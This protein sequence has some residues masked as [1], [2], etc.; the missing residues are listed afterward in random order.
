GLTTYRLDEIRLPAPT[1]FAVAGQQLTVTRVWRLTDLG[2]A[3]CLEGCTALSVLIYDRSVLRE[4]STIAVG[5]IG[6]GVL[7]ETLHFLQ[8]PA[9]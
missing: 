5:A 3:A 9:P 4:G 7:P 8:Q 6:G 1:T 2:T